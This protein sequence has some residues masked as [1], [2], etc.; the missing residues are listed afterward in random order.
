MQFFVHGLA[1]SCPEFDTIRVNGSFEELDNKDGVPPVHQ[2]LN[3]PAPTVAKWH[4][5][6]GE[7]ADCQNG[8]SNDA[9]FSE[10]ACGHIGERPLNQQC[11]SP[12]LCQHGHRRLNQSP[13]TAEDKVNSWQGWF[14][15]MFFCSWQ[16]FS[17]G[18]GRQ[19]QTFWPSI[20][21]YSP[22]QHKRHVRPYFKGKCTM[23]DL[24]WNVARHH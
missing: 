4:V 2:W 9:Q 11:I 10:L 23:Y 12:R 3:W 16:H 21:V 19:W 24:R 22:G 8:A 15:S 18:Y 1:Q 20:H 6:R 13:C 7:S 5:Y 14:H 17:V